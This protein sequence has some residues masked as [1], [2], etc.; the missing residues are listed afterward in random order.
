MAFGHV[1]ADYL[2]LVWGKAVGVLKAKPADYRSDKRHLVFQ[3]LPHSLGVGA[4][5]WRVLA[6][7]YERCSRAECERDADIGEQLVQDLVSATEK[8]LAALE[9]M[10]T[11]QA[12]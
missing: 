11:V 3:C 1:F 7:S 8:V 12:S 6:L 4:D 9:S 2:P 5:V 10:D